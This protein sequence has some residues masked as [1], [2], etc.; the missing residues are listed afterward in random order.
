MPPPA[1]SDGISDSDSNIKNKN[2]IVRV[3]SSCK[4][5]S[6]GTDF[7]R[8]STLRQLAWHIPGWR[9]LAYDSPSSKNVIE[10]EYATEWYWESPGVNGIGS[11][12]SPGG[13]GSHLDEDTSTTSLPLI[14]AP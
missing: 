14:K 12:Q 7:S 8:A 1:E 9:R 3:W 11:H 4:Y 13:I 6:G 5:E 2:S 10:V